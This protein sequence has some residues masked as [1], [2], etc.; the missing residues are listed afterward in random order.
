MSFQQLIIPVPRVA[1]NTELTKQGVP[2][3]RSQ[4]LLHHRFSLLE[5]LRFKYVKRLQ[6]PEHRCDQVT[7]LPCHVASEVVQ[8]PLHLLSNLGQ[9]EQLLHCFIS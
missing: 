8:K 4:L 6:R 1:I 5:E 3:K 9:L 2:C 7:I